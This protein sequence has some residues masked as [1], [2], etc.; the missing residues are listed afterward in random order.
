MKIKREIIF[1]IFFCFS[2]LVFGG[3]TESLE[4]Q[5]GRG[6]TVHESYA[7][8]DRTIVVSISTEE[9]DANIID[10][11]LQ[12][13]ITLPENY[14]ESEGVLFPV[15]YLLHGGEGG[16]SVWTTQGGEVESITQKASLI[17]V[18][19][20]GGFSWYTDWVKSPKGKQNW[21]SFHLYQLIPWIDQ[22]FRTIASRKGRAIAGLSMGGFGAIHYAQERPDLFSFAA[23][24]SG[25]MDLERAAAR[26]VITGHMMTHSM[27]LDGPFGRHFVLRGN[28]WRSHNPMR[29][30][31]DLRGVFVALYSGEGVSPWDFGEKIVHR[32]TARFHRALKRRG[33]H[34]LHWSYGPSLRGKA[35]WNCDGGHNFRCWNMALEEVLPKENVRKMEGKS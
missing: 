31:R 17:T 12:I 13:Y 24:F 7:M 18:M 9:V 23:S 30:V 10:R 35:P 1:F 2:S 21:E 19:P 33:I 22:N 29:R 20:E 6:I 8:T 34:H 3:G 27:P 26:G 16:A 28:K 25:M 5:S 11:P 14:T 15:L 32:M 4:L